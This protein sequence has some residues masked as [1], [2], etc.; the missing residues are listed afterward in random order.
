MSSLRLFHPLLAQE[1][2]ASLIEEHRFNPSTHRLFIM[3]N[4]R[5][6][7]WVFA[8]VV[9]AG[10]MPLWACGGA[11]EGNEHEEAVSHEHVLTEAERQEH[12]QMHAD[13]PVSAQRYAPAPAPAPGICYCTLCGKHHSS[14]CL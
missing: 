14:G 4:S 12:I 5:K 11:V 9:V 2:C 3:K 1:V 10:A 7:S 13:E 8:S 6:A